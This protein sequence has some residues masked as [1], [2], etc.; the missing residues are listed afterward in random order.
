MAVAPQIVDRIH[1][2]PFMTRKLFLRAMAALAFAALSTAYAAEEATSPPCYELRTYYAAEGK[3][4][5]LHARFREHTTAL[6]AKHGMTNVGYWVPLDNPDHRIIYLLSYPTR[7]AREKSWAEFSSDPEWK[8]VQAASEADGKIVA[9]SENRFLTQTDFSPEPKGAPEGTPH[10]FELRTYTTTPGNLPLLL[11]RF[12]EHTLGFFKKYGMTNF[13]YFTPAQGEKG[14]DNTLIYLLSHA[15][16]EAC[17]KSFAEFRADPEW[18]QV[19]A[20]SEKAGGGSLTIPD[21]VKS[22][23]LIATDYSPVK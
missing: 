19:K 20:D 2:N 10:T 7:E 8:A 6:F 18:I 12:R 15:S 4:D 23:L 3:L 22:E 11:K 1:P 5:A 17:A 14:A 16:P 21:G 9:K 13:A